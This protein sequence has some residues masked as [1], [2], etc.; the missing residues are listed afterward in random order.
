MF[1]RYFFRPAM[2]ESNA[3][4]VVRKGNTVAVYKDFN[5]CQAQVSSSVCN[6]PVSA[7]KG[8]GLRKETEDYLTSRGLRNPL[9]TIDAADV[10]EDLFGTLVPCSFQDIAR[11]SSSPANLPKNYPDLGRSPVA[12]PA[13]RK[14]DT[15]GSAPSSDHFRKT[16][17]PGFNSVETQS[18]NKPQVAGHSR[19]STDLLPNNLILGFSV[20]PRPISQQPMLCILEFDGASKGNPGKAGAGAVLRTEDGRVICRLREGL[21]IVTNNVAEYRAVIL[22]LKYALKKGFRRVQVRGDS[23]LVCMQVKGL[24]QTKNQNMI[25]L[26]KEVNELKERFL[27][28]EISHMKRE[29]NADA[30]QQA[31][32]AI[33]LPYGSISEEPGEGY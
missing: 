32:I 12:Q 10:K 33:N 2:E 15:S 6:P 5:D 4:Y 21:G 20:E 14:Q 9:Y 16:L 3:F 11:S 8:Y 19:F 13:N 22:G 31:N 26:C 28:F 30:D 7:Y 27:D 24:W 25:E 17:S 1:L 23:Q 18:I 29:Y